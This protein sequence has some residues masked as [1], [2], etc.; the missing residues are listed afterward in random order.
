MLAHFKFVVAFAVGAFFVA[1][2]AS[3]DLIVIQLHAE[4]GFVGNLDAAAFDLHASAV[5]D[6]ILLLLPGVMGVA[7]VGE[8]GRGG[9][10]VSHRH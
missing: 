8:V 6:L 2:F 4:A 7:G 5:D 1:L 3:G 10:D 9:G